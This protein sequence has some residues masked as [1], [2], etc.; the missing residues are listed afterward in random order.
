M[1]KSIV[2]YS[3]R[4]YYFINRW[5][6]TKINKLRLK[7]N[8]VEL[9]DSVMINGILHIVNKGEIKIGNGV[10]INSSLRY[11]PIS[12]H[13]CSFYTSENA[14]IEIGDKSGLSGCTLYSVKKIH[15][16]KRVLIGAGV[17]IYDT[18]FHSLLVDERLNG[19]SNIKSSPVYIYD[20]CFIGA[21]VTILKGVTIGAGSVVAA[22]SVVTKNIGENELWAGNPARYI[23]DTIYGE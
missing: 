18:D 20:D 11:N 8:S 23:R 2:V 9:G 17:N 3:F 13:P 1:I 7:A 22:C 5:I 12:H 15:I 10:K 14:V 4:I 16:G 21:N 6:T 19:D